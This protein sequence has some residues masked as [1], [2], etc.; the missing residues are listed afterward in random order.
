MFCA[1]TSR[2]RFRAD[3]AVRHKWAFMKATLNRISRLC[4]YWLPLLLIGCFLLI[5]RAQATTYVF[6]GNLPSTCSGS[7]GTYT[8][9]SLSLGYQDEITIASPTPATITVKGDFSTSQNKINASGAAA[10]L[11]LIVTGTLNLNWGSTLNANVTALAVNGATSVPFGGTITAT[12]DIILSDYVSV[13]G[14]I[15]SSAGQVK[16]GTG[17]IVSGSV[18][19]AKDI[20]MNYTAQVTGSV[21]SSNGQVQMD[22]QTFVG[23]NVTTV[24]NGD[25]TIK[26][27]SVV[28]G[29]VITNSGDTTLENEVKIGGYISSKSGDITVGY[30][31]H[32]RGSVTTSGT[33]KNYGTIN[34]SG[35]TMPSTC[36]SSSSNTPANFNAFETSTAS[37]AVTGVIKTKISAQAFSVAIVALTSAPAVKTDFAGTVSVQLVVGSG[38][39]A[40]A[41]RT[42]IAAAGSVTFAAAN[43]GRV[44]ASFTE[45]NAW[46]DVLIRM[47]YTNSAGS[48]VTACSTDH[49]AI[50]P[51]SFSVAVTDASWE[52]A[53]ATRTLN[54]TSA[55][56]GMVHK[57]GRPF[58]ITAV[59]Y[60]AAGAVTSNYAG[61]PSAVF[62]QSILPS[63]STCATCALSGTSFSGSNGTVISATS[64]YSEVGAFTLQLQDSSFASIDASDGSTAAE[65]TITSAAT[66]VGRFVPDHFTLNSS[67]VTGACNGF[68]YMG[69]DALTV[70]YVL[71]AQNYANATTAN[72]SY[73]SSSNLARSYVT[74]VAENNDDGTDL[75]ARLTVPTAY[76]ASGLYS[77]SSS[78]AK[79]SRLTSPDGPYD[80][81]ALG[82]KVTDSDGVILANPDMKA[83]TAGACGTACDSKQIGSAT[84]IRFGRLHLMNA[85]GSDRLNL[86]IPMHAQYWNG[87]AFV[88]NALDSCTTITNNNVALLNYRAGITASNVP[89]GNVLAGTAGSTTMSAGIGKLT[90]R[91]PTS[92]PG[93]KGSVDV[94]VDLGTDDPEICVATQ[95]ASM[96]WLQG[97]WSGTLY[98]DDPK[99]RATFGIYKAPTI[100]FREVY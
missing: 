15:T 69:Q 30:A 65:I 93:A 5:G 60:N 14:A 41:S 55:S 80:N 58:T 26:Y 50:R 84:K 94:C 2:H 57:A 88:T 10:N 89:Q 21:T 100:Y 83:S 32:V 13:G 20:T 17:V 6:P 42:A 91:K 67:A 37:G 43:L 62:V 56:G 40:C 96:P 73:T 35:Y 27:Q 11:N 44:N 4:L 24:T 85:H 45:S 66:S 70:Q 3:F 75:A 64:T 34:E 22:N 79:F 28:C 53:G 98:D 87:S 9:T 82:V 78:A 59:A 36:S 54:N 31:S 33:I 47:S 72:Y 51:A 29:N 95:S 25:V 99:A 1:T 68:S 18:T 90:L 97:K 16:L 61:T 74:L 77:V 81:L 39:T 71:A 76:W 86:P 63:L 12:N 92:T 7:G 46:P 48:T 19:S 38:T 52:T 49:F 23:G 8:C